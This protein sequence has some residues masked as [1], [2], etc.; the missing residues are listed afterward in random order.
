MRRVLAPVKN[1]VR[2]VKTYRQHLP[3]AV[4]AIFSMRVAVTLLRGPMKHDGAEITVLYVGRRKNFSYLKRLI[5]DECEVLEKV[6][7]YVPTYRKHLERLASRTD[8]TLID[9]GWPYNAY[10]DR[11]GEYLDLPDWL[12]MAIDL[13]DD[14]QATVKNFRKTTRNNDLR[15]IRRNA[16]R[17]EL[18]DDRESIE[19]FYEEF[20]RPFI[21]RKYS[22][23]VV[24]APKRHVVR[25]ARRGKL[26]QVIGRDGVV[27]AGVVF[28]EDDIL[29]FL[30]MGMPEHLVGEPPEGAVSALYYF[31]IVHAHELGVRAVDFTGTRPFLRDG[32]FGFKRKWGAV[33]DDTFSPNSILFK[34]GGDSDNAARFC[35]SHPLLA[36]RDDGLE[37]II[38]NKDECFTTD[39]YAK[40]D[41]TYAC[42]GIDEITI[43]DIA[44]EQGDVQTSYAGSVCEHRLIRCDAADYAGYYERHAALSRGDAS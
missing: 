43:L 36:R 3:L 1:L 27:C 5:F 29:Y 2:F 16:Y 30:W 8:I 23:D 42:D 28:P 11:S 4:D 24:L 25:R 39:R 22:D 19:S 34:P 31:G 9:I 7:S 38:L 37:L 44:D 17:Y 13:G 6:H 33:V 21:Q 10:A 18:K 41:S 32:A 20:Y 15:L 14:L 40:I 12:N 35:Q 26:L